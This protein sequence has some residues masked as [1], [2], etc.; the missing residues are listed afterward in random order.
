MFSWTLFFRATASLI[1]GRF[2]EVILF[3]VLKLDLYST[4]AVR[5]HYCN[6][7]LARFWR[8]SINSIMVMCVDIFDQATPS[9]LSSLSTYVISASYID[10]IKGWWPTLLKPSS[11]LLWV[12]WIRTKVCQL[13]VII[14]TTFTKKKK[15][16]IWFST[17]H[18][19]ALTIS[20]MVDVLF[21]LN[22]NPIFFVQKCILL[23]KASSTKF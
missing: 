9:T 12:C 22:N 11:L 6:L 7:P 4:I 20:D 10:L 3:T 5:D 13:F 16:M 18:V 2:L 19:Q 1:G 17:I 15:A 14:E 21:S 8:T 23:S